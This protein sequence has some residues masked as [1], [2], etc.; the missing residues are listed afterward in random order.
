MVVVVATGPLGAGIGGTV[1]ATAGA[2]GATVGTAATGVLAGAATGSATVAAAGTATALTGSSVAA[3][4]TAVAVDAT[5]LGAAGSAGGAMA[6]KA[7]VAS[8]VGGPIT[9]GL[10]VFGLCILGAEY[11]SSPQ[12][13]SLIEKGLEC[14]NEITFD[15][16]KPVLHDISK[17]RSK[18]MVFN[19]IVSD[20]RIKEVNYAKNNNG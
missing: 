10:T 19:E 11:E 7:V 16:W 12:K 5:V 9:L 3:V 2:S 15:C 13:M 20:E 6:G 17:E 14:Q 4:G 1:A 18:G 8:A